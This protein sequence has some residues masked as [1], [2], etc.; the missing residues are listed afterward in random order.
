MRAAACVHGTV[1]SATA[2]ATNMSV[3]TSD[4]SNNGLF[5]NQFLQVVNEGDVLR[6]L[7]LSL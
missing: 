4:T 1:V 3:L 2:F 7:S 6:S 5:M